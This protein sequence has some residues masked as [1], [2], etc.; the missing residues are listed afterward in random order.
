MHSNC[1]M[2]SFVTAIRV[3]KYTSKNSNITR[4]NLLFSCTKLCGFH[5]VFLS[6]II[7]LY[8]YTV[9]ANFIILCLALRPITASG[10]ETDLQR[11]TTLLIKTVLHH[12]NGICVKKETNIKKALLYSECLN[13]YIG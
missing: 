2:T 7:L 9:I 4:S 3:I 13:S 8:C 12:L 11:H 1:C 5:S 6:L 10:H